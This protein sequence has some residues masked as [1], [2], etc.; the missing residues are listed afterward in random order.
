MMITHI[1]IK[2]GGP[3]THIDRL[4]FAHLY[5]LAQGLINGA[6]RDARHLFAGHFEQALGGWV[7]FVF[8][9]KTEKQL[10]LG[11]EL[12]LLF[13]KYLSQLGWGSHG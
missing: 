1:W 8:V 7:R 2:T 6:Q 11:G 13:A 10:P 9:Q 4:Q 3:G 5:E 12:Q